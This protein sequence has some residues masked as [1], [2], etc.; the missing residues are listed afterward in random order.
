MTAEHTPDT[1]HPI[2]LTGEVARMPSFG[3]VRVLLIATGLILI[4]NLLRLL[5]R[6]CIGLRGRAT[7]AVHTHIL[8]LT[9]EWFLFGRRIRRSKTVTPISRLTAVRFENRQ[10]YLYILVGAGALVTGILVGM[11]WF[12][13]GLRAGYPYLVLV[14]AA[15][16]A[17]G[18]II[19]V[20][21]FL[22]VPKGEGRS[23]LVLGLGPWIVRVVGVDTS[24]ATDFIT[25]VKEAWKP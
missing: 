19:D 24:R 10:R 12:L 17:A 23:H 9:V 2:T 8:T 21:M 11:Q 1:P 13:D 18:V 15:V 7:A 6:Y 25:A 14:G 5:A 4:R 3:P 20:V 22:F 16:I